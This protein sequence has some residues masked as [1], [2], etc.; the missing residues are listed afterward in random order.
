MFTAYFRAR[1]GR[2]FSRRRALSRSNTNFG[3]SAHNY[4]ITFLALF[5]FLKKTQYYDS[6]SG[7]PRFDFVVGSPPPFSDRLLALASSSSPN[8]SSGMRDFVRAGGGTPTTFL[9]RNMM[10]SNV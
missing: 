4:T 3:K 2:M 8:R 6:T 5:F 10:E 7:R 9:E 1:N